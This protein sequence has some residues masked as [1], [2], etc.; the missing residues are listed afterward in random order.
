LALAGASSSIILGWGGLCYGD[1]VST[2]LDVMTEQL[3]EWGLEITIPEILENL[4]VLIGI[5]GAA[6][7]NFKG[8]VEVLFPL[9]TWVTEKIDFTM[10]KIIKGTDQH[11]RMINGKSDLSA[12][13]TQVAKRLNTSHGIAIKQ[14]IHSFL[15]HDKLDDVKN[16][17]VESLVDLRGPDYLSINKS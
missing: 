10:K 8:Y 1:D 13:I 4:L 2:Q 15:A 11:P 6:A 7:V 12:L 5:A 16:R 9:T 3:A 17:E 14:K